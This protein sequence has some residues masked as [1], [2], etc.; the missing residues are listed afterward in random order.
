MLKGLAAARHHLTAK[1]SGENSVFFRDV[2]TNGKSGA[3]FS[4]NANLVLLDQF[5][6][7]F[8]ADRR[9]V[10]LDFFFVGD[11]IDEVGGGNRLCHTVAPATALHQ[12]IEE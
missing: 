6:D 9:F 7:V 8:E 10:Q 3:L 12:V 11:G 2:I 4:A 1:Q 5:A